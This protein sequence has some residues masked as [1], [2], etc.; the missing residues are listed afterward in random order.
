MHEQGGVGL[1]KSIK[2]EEVDSDEQRNEALV[3][4]EEL[5]GLFENG[6]VVHLT[7]INADRPLVGLLSG[8]LS[9]TIILV[10]PSGRS[11]SG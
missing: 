4:D 5:P 7:I 6:E 10:L 9:I 3:L 8:S 2:E 1:E 11:L